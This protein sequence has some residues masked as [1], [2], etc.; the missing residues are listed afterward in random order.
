MLA[1]EP[2]YTFEQ[3]IERA[4]AEHNPRAERETLSPA[5]SHA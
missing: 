2:P 5:G 4:M 3:G 1:Y